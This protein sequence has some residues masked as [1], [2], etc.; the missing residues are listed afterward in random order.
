MW[1]SR[2]EYTALVDARAR[3][4]TKADW[5]LIQVNLLHAELGQRK[6][7]QTGKPTPVPMFQREATPQDTKTPIDLFED[8]G[9]VQ[10]RLDGIDSDDHGRI[11][12][13]A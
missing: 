5:L 9:D 7:E 2:K 12:F 11:V 8:M 13:A 1:I 3:A 6:Y 10:A 4:E